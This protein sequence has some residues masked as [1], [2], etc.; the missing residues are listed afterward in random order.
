[1][2]FKNARQARQAREDLDMAE[3]ILLYEAGW[4]TTS[5]T[6]G[7]FVLWTRKHPDR[8]SKLMIAVPQ[9]MAI[10]MQE[11]FDEPE[12]QECEDG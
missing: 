3:K 10:A 2:R 12:E 4:G 8:C 5:S 11:F 9:T 6:P 7:C 1:M